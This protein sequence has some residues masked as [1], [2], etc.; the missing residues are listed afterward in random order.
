MATKGKDGNKKNGS[1]VLIP[2]KLYFRI[3]EVAELCNLPAYVLRF[4]ET[5]FPQLKPT[6]GSTGQR[7]YRY[8]DVEFVLRIKELLYD[9]GFTISGARQHLRAE[10]KGGK[11]QAALKFPASIP[12]EELKR[13]R[14][15]LREILVMLSSKKTARRH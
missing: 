14:Q 15:G 5:E 13:V 2:D 3:G 8:R 11:A 9:E 7:M 12:P 10:T 4:W 6:K 1:E